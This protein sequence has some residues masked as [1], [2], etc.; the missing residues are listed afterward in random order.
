MFKCVCDREMRVLIKFL[1]KKKERFFYLIYGITEDQ[2]A[3][4]TCFKISGL[5]I[6]GSQLGADLT[7]DSPFR[8]LH[9]CHNTGLCAVNLQLGLPSMTKSL[10]KN[11]LPERRHFQTRG[12]IFSQYYVK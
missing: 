6:L 8:V 7:S 11:W 2:R 10:S 4:I 12:D 3:C 1:L 9:V 5:E